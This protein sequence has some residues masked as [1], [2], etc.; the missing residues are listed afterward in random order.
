MSAGSR[1]SVADRE[2]ALLELS[3]HLGSGRLD[4]AEFDE[5]SAA[6]STATTKTELAEL[7]ADLPG[8]MPPPAPAP[9]PNPLRT[10]VVT[11]GAIAAFVLV[12]ALV[13]GDWW[14]LLVALGAPALFVLARR[15]GVLRT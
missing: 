2:R 13:T 11:A 14:W 6:V 7:F 5:R 3:Q 1:V 9:V 10:L 8:S 15:K 12:L 4:L